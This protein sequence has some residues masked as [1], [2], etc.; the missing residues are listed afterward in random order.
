M[1]VTVA[2]LVRR[3]FSRDTERIILASEIEREHMAW[4]DLVASTPAVSRLREVDSENT[5]LAAHVMPGGAQ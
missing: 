1:L 5:G 2:A 3:S 4:L